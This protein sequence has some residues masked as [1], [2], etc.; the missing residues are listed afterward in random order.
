MRKLIGERSLTIKSCFDKNDK[1]TLHV[2]KFIDEDT[3]T[4]I[5]SLPFY[6]TKRETSD[7]TN[8]AMQEA[9]EDVFELLR[10]LYEAGKNGEQIKFCD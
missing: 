6:Y 2:I 10:T 8:K 4:L 1:E 5:K 9:V 3:N 7:G